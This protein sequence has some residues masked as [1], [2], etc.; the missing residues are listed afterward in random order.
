MRSDNARKSRRAQAQTLWRLGKV[1][2]ASKVLRM[3]TEAR[4]YVEVIE[5]VEN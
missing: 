4:A 3:K 2:A 1:G 5:I